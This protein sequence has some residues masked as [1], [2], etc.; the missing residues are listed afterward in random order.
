MYSRHAVR[1]HQKQKQKHA[2]V[3]C[4]VKGSK[5]GWRGGASGANEGEEDASTGARTR[6]EKPATTVELTRAWTPPWTERG[7][8]DVRVSPRGR[9]GEATSARL[10]GHGGDAA[11]HLMVGACHIACVGV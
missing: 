9:G 11:K 10:L 8:K 4:S 6:V 1:D 2:A 5:N 3:S 7:W